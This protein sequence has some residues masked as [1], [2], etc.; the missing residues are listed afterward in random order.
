MKTVAL[1]GKNDLRVMD[2]P[3]PSIG[4]GEL[5]VRVAVCGVCGTDIHKVREG[6]SK[7]PVVL[8]HEIS[9]VVEKVGAGVVRFGPGDRVTMAHH[10]PCEKCHYCKRGDFSMC[11]AFKESNLDPGGFAEFVRVPKEHAAKTTFPVPE[12]LSLEEA[13]FMEPL[14]CALRNVKRLSLQAG[15]TAVVVGL[16]PIGLMMLQL[17]R[18]SNG[19]A[20]GLDLDPARV[21]FAKAQGFEAFT[22]SGDMFRR[23][24]SRVADTRGADAVIVTAGGPSLV[25]FFLEWLRDGG[26]LNIFSGFYPDH[27]VTLDWNALYTREISVLSSYSPSPQD[28]KEA[29]ELLAKRVISVSSF[30]GSSFALEELPQALEL[31]AQR[32]IWKAMIKPEKVPELL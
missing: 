29:L 11:R 21:D 9:G 20:I 15:D 14:A 7:T 19:S 25:P 26:T 4:P 28:L 8:G 2:R 16:G 31:L 32:K 1:F 17:V 18:W 22:D 23:A 30:T 24:L 12:D 5:L 27:S 10:V 6:L 13:S 3:V